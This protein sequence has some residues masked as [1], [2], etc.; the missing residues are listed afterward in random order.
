MTIWLTKNIYEQDVI[1]NDF[2][3]SALVGV[4]TLTF[5]HGIKIYG[6]YTKAP[7]EHWEKC[8]RYVE[9]NLKFDILQPWLKKILKFNILKP[10]QVDSIFT[11]VWLSLLYHYLTFWNAPEWPN[12]TVFW[13]NHTFIMVEENFEVWL[14]K[15]L[16]KG[17]IL[18]SSGVIIPSPWLKKILKFDF[19]KRSRMA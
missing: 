3:L 13:S 14:S 1:N 9:E 4:G 2:S 12:F 8:G 15:T 5:H 16:Q 17:L 11:N 19:L 6:Q 7:T 10:S 18:L